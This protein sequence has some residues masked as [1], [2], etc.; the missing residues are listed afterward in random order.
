MHFVYYLCI[1]V[2]MVFAVR[3]L[4]IRD[5]PMIY[6]RYNDTVNCVMYSII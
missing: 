6:A 2:F 1:V 3:L 4:Y 5:G